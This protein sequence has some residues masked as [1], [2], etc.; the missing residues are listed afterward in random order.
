MYTLITNLEQSPTLLLGLIIYLP[1]DIEEIS[2]R[3]IFAEV[4]II[5][6][7][8]YSIWLM[9]MQK[10][11]IVKDMESVYNYIDSLNYILMEG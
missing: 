2:W 8:G 3:I 4:Y 11:I 6:E 5:P 7:Q 1:K 10:L 9:D